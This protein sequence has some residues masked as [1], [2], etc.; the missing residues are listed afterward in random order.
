MLKCSLFDFLVNISLFDRRSNNNHCQFEETMSSP[1][2]LGGSSSKI[3]SSRRVGNS[4]RSFPASI[5]CTKYQHCHHPSSIIYHESH[6]SSTIHLYTL[7]LII[8]RDHPLSSLI[9]IVII[10]IIIII[11]IINIM[12]IIWPSWPVSCIQTSLLFLQVSNPKQGEF[13]LRP[14]WKSFWTL[15]WAARL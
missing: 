4:P 12:N 10:T 11:N 6:P 1:T 9:L 8:T 14:E 7:S 13:T 5:D 2:S 15:M 3:F